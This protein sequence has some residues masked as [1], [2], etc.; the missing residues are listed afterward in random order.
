[1]RRRRVSVPPG[2]SQASPVATSFPPRQP[3][4]SRPRR[5]SSIQEPSPLA[6]LFVHANGDNAEIFDR[7]RERRMS[8]VGLA[9]P[10]SQS[11][12]VP[13]SVVSP[14][15]KPRSHSRN[16]S[17]G[18]QGLQPLSS[19]LPPP[20]KLQPSLL[21]Q[22]PLSASKPDSQQTS[23]SK[24]DDTIRAAP[25]SLLPPAEEVKR[26]AIASPTLTP[27]RTPT[28]SRPQSPA[29]TRSKRG[30]IP[31]PGREGSTI[32]MSGSGT[33][34]KA[35]EVEAR[36]SDITPT[37]QMRNEEVERDWKE[38]LDSMEERQMR[39]EDMLKRLVGDA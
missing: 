30:G 15:S 21:S 31:F 7:L 22:E 35:S 4:A 19:L 12:P 5:N 10:N 24:A 33:I 13:S 34:G 37:S 26:S 38:R 6:R 18:L 14:R 36:Q 25:R 2:S 17:Q 29:P 3:P 1:M 23:K 20:K 32:S 9:M 27:M 11:Q 39:I 8:L 28:H 16:F